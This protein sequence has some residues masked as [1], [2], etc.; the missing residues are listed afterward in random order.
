[1]TLSAPELRPGRG[2]LSW[3]GT[4]EATLRLLRD[5]G[6]G[7]QQKGQAQELELMQTSH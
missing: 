6:P 1:M 4:G 7:S 3:A 5:P 2:Q